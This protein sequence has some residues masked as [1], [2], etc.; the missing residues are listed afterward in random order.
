MVSNSFRP[1][2]AYSLK[3]RDLPTLPWWHCS[4]SYKYDGIRA[5][6]IDGTVLSR[7]LIPL[8]NRCLQKMF[9]HL[10]GLDGEIMLEK[11]FQVPMDHYT[12]QSAVRKQEGEHPFIFY[13]FDSFDRPEDSWIS[14]QRYLHQRQDL[15]ATEGARIVDQET[16]SCLDHLQDFEDR[17]LQLGMEGVVVRRHGQEY[18]YGRSTFLSGG[19]LR[20]KR[21]D[22]FEGIIVGME[23]AQANLNEAQED[24]FGLIKR[25]SHQENKVGKGMVGAF[26]VLY[27]GKTHR[28]SAGA[29]THA[30]RIELWQNREK[31]LGDTLVAHLTAKHFAYGAKD[32]L[33]HA[34][35]VS[36]RFDLKEQP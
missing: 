25:S 26:L 9:R 13:V 28:V 17:A 24:A 34:R 6:V 21:E 33:R 16:L 4:A 30:Q 8:P 11:S 10:E 36:I 27:K 12:I 22:T 31:Y 23:E 1:T 3:P 2:L 15:K 35:A 19:F 5:L 7:Q 18:K 14:R 32:E 20:L 29:L